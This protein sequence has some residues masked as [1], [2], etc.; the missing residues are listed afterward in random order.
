[1]DNPQ[2][3]PRV[4]YETP[5]DGWVYGETGMTLRDYFAAAA[6]TGLLANSFNDGVQKPLSHATNLERAEMAYHAADEMLK[7]RAL[8]R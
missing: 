1:M 2:A 3:F 5:T 7:R 8:Y 4:G 6:L